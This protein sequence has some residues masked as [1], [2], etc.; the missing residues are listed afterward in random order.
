MS[1]IV[2]RYRWLSTIT[3]IASY[4][5]PFFYMVAQAQTLSDGQIAQQIEKQRRMV[6]VDEYGCVKYPADDEIVVCGPD[7]EK[8]RQR[9]PRS[10]AVDTYRIRRGEAVS[11][12]RAAA[13][14][15]SGCGRVGIDI[16]CTIL[17]SNT[18]SMGPAPPPM[19]PDFA[20]VIKGLPDQEAVV[21]EDTPPAENPT[22]SS[23][24]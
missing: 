15:R 4:C 10:D 6:A 12:T 18:V 19:P 23:L 5:M 8:K 11:T 22:G 24:F 9:L 2:A 13:K 21:P 14:D 17:P 1:R 7:L 16:S 3:I 20:D